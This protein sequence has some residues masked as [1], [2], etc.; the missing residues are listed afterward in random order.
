MARKKKPAPRRSSRKAPVVSPGRGISLGWIAVVVGVIVIGWFA[1]RSTRPPADQAAAPVATPASAAT[2]APATKPA[3]TPAPAPKP[4]AKPK[5]VAAAKPAPTPAATPVVT[6]AAAP[7]AAPAPAPIATPAPAPAPAP[8]AAP[9][10]APVAASAISAQ[11]ARAAL[12]GQQAAFVDARLANGFV[13]GHV[14]GAVNLPAA[15]FDQ[16]FAA[17]GSALPHDKKLIVYCADAG[18][19]DGAQVIAELGKHGFGNA[20]LLTG[21][22]A[23]WTA[24]GNP[25]QRGFGQ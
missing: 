11:D 2:P 5:P 14:P 13:F 8:V 19:P 4:A 7:T 15:Q 10:P 21:G 12:D 25:V 24:A 22:W 20:V 1:L 9:D 18:C 16:A 23:A 17:R 6:P 3:V